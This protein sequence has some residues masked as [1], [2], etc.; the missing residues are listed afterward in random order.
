MSI[1]KPDIPSLFAAGAAYVRLQ[2]TFKGAVLCLRTGLHFETLAMERIILEQ[3]AWIYKVHN[4]EGDFFKVLPNECIRDLKRLIPLAGRLYGVLSDK[5]HIK[6]TSTLDYIWAENNA[7]RV[8][9]RD[10]RQT[11]QNAYLLLRIYDMFCIVGEYIYADLLRDHRYLRKDHTGRYVPSEQRISL[12]LISKLRSI[13]K[14][15]ERRIN[16][17]MRRE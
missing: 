9:L 8:V 14:T 2:N 6:P 5:L 15:L 3:L 13:L 16:A 17:E 10:H 7:L 1:E 11:I 12:D 4:Y